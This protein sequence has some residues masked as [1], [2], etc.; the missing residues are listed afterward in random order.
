MNNKVRVLQWNILADG[1]SRDGFVCSPTLTTT[2]G[3]ACTSDEFLTMTNIAK[4]H[5]VMNEVIDLFNTPE[6]TEVYERVLKWENRWPK[7]IEQIRQQD[8]DIL[9]FQEMDH[10]AVLENP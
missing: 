1:L 5:N 2:N 7:M 9:C 3:R 10:Y 6:N 8:P 4:N